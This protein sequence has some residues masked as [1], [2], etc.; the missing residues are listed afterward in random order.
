[1]IISS[2]G[3][4]RSKCQSC[5]VV[6]TECSVLLLSKSYLPRCLGNRNPIPQSQPLLCPSANV[7]QHSPQLSEHLSPLCCF[8]PHRTP[9]PLVSELHKLLETSSLP[10]Q[11]FCAFVFLYIALMSFPHYCHTAVSPAFYLKINS[12]LKSDLDTM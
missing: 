3:S 4:L 9:Q 1:M 5:T 11:N 2:A 8:I 10:S 6:V 12:L 7:C